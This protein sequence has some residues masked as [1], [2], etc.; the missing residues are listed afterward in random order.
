MMEMMNVAI[1]NVKI[2]KFSPS[3]ITT[4]AEY[5]WE[6]LAPKWIPAIERVIETR[7][8]QDY[9]HRAPKRVKTCEVCKDYGKPFS[10]KDLRDVIKYIKPNGREHTLLTGF[11]EANWS[12]QRIVLLNYGFKDDCKSSEPRFYHPDW[13]E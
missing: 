10:K 4:Y 11:E 13:K 8:S 2:D 9:T 3:T 6:K 12:R 5:R 1:D 7:R